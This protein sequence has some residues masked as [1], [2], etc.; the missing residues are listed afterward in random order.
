MPFHSCIGFLP[1][2]P[3]RVNRCHAQRS[4]GH[5]LS[6]VVGLALAERARKIRGTLYSAC[7]RWRSTWEEAT[8]CLPRS[9]SRRVDFRSL[10]HVS[11]RIRVSVLSSKG[12][13]PSAGR[14]SGRP[15]TKGGDRRC[16]GQPLCGMRSFT[17]GSTKVLRAAHGLEPDR[18]LRTIGPEV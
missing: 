12:T 6:M 8:I 14:A 7:G 13:G 5:G 3:N 11:R 17:I 9:T 18:I 4:L 15:V 1:R 16:G 2:E 10:G